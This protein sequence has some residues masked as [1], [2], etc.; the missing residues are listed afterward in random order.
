MRNI[1]TP[2][3]PSIP[4]VDVREGGPARHARE[5]RVRARGLRDTCVGWLPAP[6]RLMLPLL[7]RVARRWLTRSQSP[8]VHEVTAIA[9]TLAFPGIWF[10][11]N[12]YQW[13]CTA[14]GREEDGV[15]W[16]ARTLDWP[17]H[18]LGRYVE[19]ARAEGA[20]GEFFN[21]T[22]PLYSPPRPDGFNLDQ[23]GAAAWTHLPSGRRSGR[24]RVR[25]HSPALDS[26]DQLLA[27]CS[28]RRHAG[29]ANAE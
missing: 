4:V 20:A 3:L 18:G 9:A 16:L 5:A 27:A 12:S 11:N 28:R 8:Y 6:A 1:V 15:P 14:L 21:V 26:V 10:L 25:P 29:E 24:Q 22:W 13:S 19:I 2:G 7:D 17:F 23:P